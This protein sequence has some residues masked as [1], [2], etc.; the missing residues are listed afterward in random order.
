MHLFIEGA[1][2][3]SGGACALACTPYKTGRFGEQAGAGGDTG[4]C[5]SCRTKGK[6][7]EKGLAGQ[8]SAETGGEKRSPAT[9]PRC[10]SVPVPVPAVAR[11]A[12]GGARTQHGPGHVL[13][14]RC[15]NPSS[16]LLVI[17]KK[18]MK[19]T[20]KPSIQTRFS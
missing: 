12:G 2:P 18:T 6:A 15:A 8:G 3:R 19:K 4:G 10:S 5:L 14:S 20:N 13:H 11:D 1:P 9:H 17:K 7:G 16:A